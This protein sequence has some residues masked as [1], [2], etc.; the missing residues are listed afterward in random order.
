M[1]PLWQ[2]EPFCAKLSV[3]RRHLP[4]WGKNGHPARAVILNCR[5]IALPFVFDADPIQM[6]DQ[7]GR[8]YH[9]YKVQLNGLTV[10][11]EIDTGAAGPT[12]SHLEICFLR[13]T[14]RKSSVALQTYSSK[15]LTL[16]CQM[17][18]KVTY[19]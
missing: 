11:M 3:Q 16:L 8:G 12:G 9:L 5:L 4:Q 7:V 19:V 17:K 13:S 1:L 15:P 10:E 2:P 18:V 14:L 6:V